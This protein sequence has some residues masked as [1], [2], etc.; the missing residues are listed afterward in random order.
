VF[1]AR[2]G[3]VVFDSLD[4]ESDATRTVSHLSEEPFLKNACV[5]DRRV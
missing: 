4:R 3:Q 1:L 5:I 2:E